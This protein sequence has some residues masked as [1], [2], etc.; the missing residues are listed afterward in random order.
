MEY[1][2]EAAA[3]W[4]GEV[5]AVTA[6]EI[7]GSL[8]AAVQELI[9]LEADV[10]V[11]YAYD[12]VEGAKAVE[13]LGKREI[14]V[15]LVGNAI[16]GEEYALWVTADNVAIGKAAGEYLAERMGGVGSVLVLEGPPG[17]VTDLRNEGF[18]QAL[19]AYPD[20]SVVA[21]DNCGNQR[22]T[23]MTD[24][25]LRMED[26]PDIGGIFAHSDEMALGA[27]DSLE[28][29]YAQTEAVVSV[30]GS[31]EVVEHL[32]KNHRYLRM[33][34]SYTPELVKTAV[35]HAIAYLQGEDLPEEKQVLMPL[36]P[37]SP[38]NALEHFDE[39][40]VY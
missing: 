25:M 40:A 29:I 16:D 35:E 6:P 9:D 36:D 14:P 20:M 27:V 32:V 5:A 38:T 3:A 39:N 13:E 24:V 34:W 22:E 28:A 15:I 17:Q 23:A 7:P 11:M 2:K 8:L 31:K 10:V 30:G 37:I 12:P 18:F 33:T 26:D 21:H 19:S 1:A 4:K